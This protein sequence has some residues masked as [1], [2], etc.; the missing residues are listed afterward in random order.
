MELNIYFKGHDV[1]LDCNTMSL[2]FVNSQDVSKEQ[3]YKYW[4]Q[5]Y[6]TF[7]DFAANNLHRMDEIY[8]IPEFFQ[9]KDKIDALIEE[10]K[11]VYDTLTPFTYKEAFE[12]PAESRFRV[13]V[14]K[15]IGVADMIEA[16][17]HTR[18]NTD[19]IKL[20]QKVYNTDGSFSHEIEMN[21]IYEVHQVNGTQLGIED[22]LYAVKCWC[23]STNKEHWL[24]IEEKYKDDPLT[25]IAS[26]FRVHESV[27]P[28]IKCLKR[29]GDIL[30][31][32]LIDDYTPPA[33]DPIVPLNKDQYFGFLQ[34]QA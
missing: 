14:F 1:L 30:L 12:L 9:C 26:T 33:D 22:P 18:L 24:W 4:K 21:N 2:S 5:M 16:M 7:E 31:M 17:G 25:A 8:A 28:H 19:G 3:I 23:T 6:P 15:N 27:I 29:Q 32:E 34:S 13:E 11:E 10:I 20:K